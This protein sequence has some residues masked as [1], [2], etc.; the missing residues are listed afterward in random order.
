MT[1]DGSTYDPDVDEVR[2]TSQLGRVYHTMLDGEWW[3]LDGLAAI[4]KGSPASVSARLRDLRKTRFGEHVIERTRVGGGTYLYR[5]TPA[6]CGLLDGHVDPDTDPPRT[7][8]VPVCG[9]ERV[10]ADLLEALRLAAAWGGLPAEAE[11]L[12]RPHLASGV[13]CEW[14]DPFPCYGGHEVTA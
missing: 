11:A 12:V 10:I 4:A 3:A 2:L 14:C 9:H 1:F 7:V 5:L 13:P 6:P 8:P